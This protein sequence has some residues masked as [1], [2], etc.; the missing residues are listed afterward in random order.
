M[1]TCCSNLAFMES[2]QSEKPAL[3]GGGAKTVSFKQDELRVR[4][5][6]NPVELKATS[7]PKPK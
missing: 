3:N 7:L 6:N 2:S 4:L 1:P 5:S